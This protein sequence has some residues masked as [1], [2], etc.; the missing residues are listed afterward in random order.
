MEENR[1]KDKKLRLK[2]RHPHYHAATATED[3]N[4]ATQMQNLQQQVQTLST[5]LAQFMPTQT[6]HMPT[7][8]ASPAIHITH[9]VEDQGRPGPRV[10][11]PGSFR[12][13]HNNICG[14]GKRKG[15]HLVSVTVVVKQD[16]FNRQVPWGAML[17]WSS[18]DCWK[19]PGRRFL[20]CPTR[21]TKFGLWCSGSLRDRFWQSA[22]YIW[23]WYVWPLTDYRQYATSR[24]IYFGSNTSPKCHFTTQTEATTLTICYYS[25]VPAT[26]EYPQTTKKEI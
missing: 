9:T 25:W 19:P 23:W 2:T 18:R 12:G 5:Q 7:T 17:I 8:K 4:L 22:H 1:R 16:I 10:S 14:R 24:H 21:E 20:G 6:H 26:Q 11:R 15:L 13:A 3:T